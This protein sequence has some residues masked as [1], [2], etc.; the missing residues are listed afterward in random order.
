MINILIAEDDVTLSG[1]YQ[2]V[3]EGMDGFRVLTVVRTG[4]ELLEYV[5]EAREDEAVPDVIILDQRLPGR[6]GMELIPE[7]K[8]KCGNTKIII[9]SGDSRIGADAVKSGADMFL[10]KPFGIDQLLNAVKTVFEGSVR[11]P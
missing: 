9:V 4:E 6:S 8:E 10:L 11:K 2:E 1:L 3:L 5:R 7:I